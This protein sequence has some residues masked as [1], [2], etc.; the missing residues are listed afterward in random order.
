[1]RS[2]AK[3]MSIR[4]FIGEIGP[5]LT[6]TL[7][8]ILR[9]D[10]EFEIVGEGGDAVDLLLRINEVHADVV[11]LR[12]PAGGREPGICSHLLLEYPNL[13]VVLL[14]DE[15]GRDILRRLMLREERWNDASKESLRAALNHHRWK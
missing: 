2:P 9:A 14:P 6:S 12:Q 7:N 5:E 15:K 10:G 8:E 1:M 3:P 11:I 4:I 13:A